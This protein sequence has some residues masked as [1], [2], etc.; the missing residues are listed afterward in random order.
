MKKRN[1]TQNEFDKIKRL[2]DLK[3][4]VPTAARIIGKSDSVLYYVRRFPDMQ[5]YLAAGRKRVQDS[6]ERT[7]LKKR[8]PLLRVHNPQLPMVEPMRMQTNVDPSPFM[9][10]GDE[11]REIHAKVK[12]LLDLMTP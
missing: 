11:V 12:K 9:S 2:L 6:M 3:V 5:S 10:I 7:A 1:L 8:H 4:P